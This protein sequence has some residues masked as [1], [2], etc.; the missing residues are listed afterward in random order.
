MQRANSSMHS[1]LVL[2]L[3]FMK[4]HKHIWAFHCLCV[5]STGWEESIRQLQT[6]VTFGRSPCGSSA[7]WSQFHL[8]RI[9]RFGTEHKAGLALKEKG[10]KGSEQEDFFWWNSKFSEY[11][12]FSTGQSFL[13]YTD[14][15]MPPTWER[16]P[17]RLVCFHTGDLCMTT[18]KHTK[19]NSEKVIPSHT[20]VLNH[21]IT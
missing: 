9:L 21:R 13:F 4:V 20:A 11:Q 19:H 7:I 17:V 1:D 6:T 3:L 15:L 18:T 16:K 10:V 12:T 14:L 2:S 8:A 5:G